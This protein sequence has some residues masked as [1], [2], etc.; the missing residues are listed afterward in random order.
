M[1]HLTAV[2]GQMLGAITKQLA[3]AGV[4]GIAAGVD[5]PAANGDVDI[6]RIKLGAEAATAG[7]LR[8]DER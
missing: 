7:F 8:G 2:G 1:A 4:D 3:G 6:E 5:L